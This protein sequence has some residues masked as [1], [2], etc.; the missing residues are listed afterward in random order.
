MYPAQFVYTGA[1]EFDD[2]PETLDYKRGIVE[3]EMNKVTPYAK[4][5]GMVYYEGPTEED[6]VL[7]IDPESSQLTNEICDL[8]GVLAGP[9][10]AW[11]GGPGTGSF[12]DKCCLVDDPAQTI[13]LFDQFADTY[14]IT[15][16]EWVGT[17]NRIRLCVWEGEFVGIQEGQFILFY[18]DGKDPISDFVQPSYPPGYLE[19]N[20]WYFQQEASEAYKKEDPQ[21]SPIGTYL[22]VEFPEFSVEVSE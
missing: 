8:T 12:S 19:L 16:G 20:K 3:Y 21:N 4:D 17:A 10:A 22:G 6:Y 1:I 5:I 11:Q 7:L 13:G 9:V 15:A 14:T 2:L 18:Y